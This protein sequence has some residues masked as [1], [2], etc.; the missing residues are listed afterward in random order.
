MKISVIERERPWPWEVAELVQAGVTR[1]HTMQVIDIENLNNV[2]AMLAHLGEI[3]IW[4]S[5]S[6]IKY[7][8]HKHAVKPTV[9]ALIAD[10][11]PLTGSLVNK[12]YLPF[13]LSQQIFLRHA[14]IKTI[15]TFHYAQRKELEQALADGVL[16]Y[17][18]V[19]KPNRGCG[20]EGVCLVE[21]VAAIHALPNDISD[22]VFQPYLVNSGDYRVLVLGG[23][24]LGAVHRIARA[25]EFRNNIS[26]GGRAEAVTDP[27]LLSRLEQM[28]GTV[29]AWSGLNFFGLDVLPCAADGQW[30]FLELNTTPDWR[31]F[32]GATGIP[33][34]THVMAFCEEWC[35]RSYASSATRKVAVS[36]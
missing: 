31:G 36:A 20:G 2:S 11:L 27:L 17:P 6:L 7:F 22:F 4:R 9:M 24:L 15:P 19:Q 35:K 5:S 32:Q 21:M 10:R 33:V 1:G 18:F 23:G 28:A 34:A 13:K 3:V 30:Y 14:S 29:A 12:P 16:V 25:G 26:Q 8:S